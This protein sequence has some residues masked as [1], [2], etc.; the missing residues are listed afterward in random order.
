MGNSSS[1]PAT[2]NSLFTRLRL[3]ALLLLCAVFLFASIQIPWNIVF[4]RS[5]LA[6]PATSRPVGTITSDFAVNGNGGATY[7]IPIEVPPGTHGVQPNISLVYNSQSGNGLLGVGWNLAGLSVIARCGKIP[8]ING[9]RSGVNFDSNDRF[10]FN[11]Q[12]LMGVSG[13]YGANGTEYHTERETWTK[14]F[15]KTVAGQNGPRSFTVTTKDGHQLEFGVTSESRILARGRSDG[16]VQVWA[17]NKISDRNGN[18]VEVSYQ[19]DPQTDPTDPGL[20]SDF[21]STPF[22]GYLPTKIRYTGNSGVTPLHLVTFEYEDRS[23]QIIA[24][25][26]GSEAQTTKRLASIKTYVD[27]DGDGGNIA[28][29]GN[30]VKEYRLAYQYGT[31]TGRS[32]VTQIEECDAAEVCLPATDFSYENGEQKFNP[33]SVWL[34]NANF[35][36]APENNPSIMADVNGDGISDIVDFANT[37]VYVAISALHHC[38]MI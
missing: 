20:I 36:T 12:Q 9:V 13:D 11:G 38:E 31:A 28:T 18:F 15:S 7:T 26:G 27:L 5:T 34:D 22:L 25:T 30:L 16:A 24:Y 37:G 19:T 1:I 17:L 32:Q 29:A 2:I 23:D 8:A 35:P 10:C 21:I 6:T 3:N 33:P 4:A 14:F